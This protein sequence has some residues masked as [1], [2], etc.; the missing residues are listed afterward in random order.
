M[1][2]GLEP[3]NR[4]DTAPPLPLN[5]VMIDLYFTYHTSLRKSIVCFYRD[6]ASMKYTLAIRRH[7]YVIYEYY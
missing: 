3:E 7:A 5:T 4:V 1:S 2:A 6:S